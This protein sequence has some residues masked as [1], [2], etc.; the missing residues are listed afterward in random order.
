MSHSNCSFYKHS[1]SFPPNAMY[2]QTVSETYDFMPHVRHERF[3]L[4]FTTTSLKA[5]PSNLANCLRLKAE[6]FQFFAQNTFKFTDANSN[7]QWEMPEFQLS[8]LIAS[9]YSLA[10][11]SRATS[12][13]IKAMNILVTY[14]VYIWGEPCCVRC[15]TSLTLQHTN[16]SSV[17]VYT[18]RYFQAGR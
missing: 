4:R 8:S 16:N 13:R 2:Y 7:C 10:F 3:A 5:M 14:G 15:D 12:W 6:D 17:N 1:N 11:D 18:T 9:N